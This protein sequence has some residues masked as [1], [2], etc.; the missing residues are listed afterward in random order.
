MLSLSYSPF[1]IIVCIAIGIAL[2]VLLYRRDTRFNSLSKTLRA[3]LYTLRAAAVS[4]LCFLLLSPM[5]KTQQTEIKKP[6]VVIAQDASGSMRSEIN[7][8]TTV[9]N[10]LNALETTLG[11]TFDV[12]KLSFGDRVRDGF[13]ASQSDKK[14]ERSSSY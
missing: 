12:K 2:S 5:I 14:L 3:V 1:F 13:N 6:V 9:I 8:S 7:D 10:K 4:T 11:S